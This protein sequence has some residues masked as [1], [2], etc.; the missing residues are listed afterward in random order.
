MDTTGTSR[1]H[2]LSLSPDAPGVI[3]Y[4][5]G[6][7]G[8]EFETVLSP[9]IRLNG[10]KKWYATVI[11]YSIWYSSPNVNAAK[12]HKFVYSS[13]GATIALGTYT[14]TI[15]DGLYGFTDV[16]A[17]LTAAV[18]A[19]GHGSVSTPVFNFVA[20]EGAQTVSIGTT[21]AG[22]TL[23]WT[24]ADTITDLFGFN[25]TDSTLSGV[26]T[27]WTGQN[28]A[29]FPRGIHSYRIHCSVCT[30]SYLGGQIGDTI[31]SVPLEATTNSQIINSSASASAHIPVRES[32]INSIRC[33]ITDQAGNRI[34]IAGENYSIT[35]SIH[36]MML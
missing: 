26:G 13:T 33:Y 15:Q 31:C 9:P 28:R 10:T 25:A 7:D 23:L 35:F 12:G 16:A 4:E 24:T 27:I 2:Y 17:Y 21:V 14:I 5:Q 11:D 6:E 22:L 3:R 32:Y 34:N 18:L 20:N 19:F 36:S 30:G 29:D 1:P 8:E